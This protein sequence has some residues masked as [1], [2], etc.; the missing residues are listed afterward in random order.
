MNGSHFIVGTLLLGIISIS[1]ATTQKTNLSNALLTITMNKNEQKNTNKILK[2]K[3]AKLNKN[4]N[5]FSGRKWFSIH[6]IAE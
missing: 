5:T 3:K 2:T 6:K 4:H 1:I